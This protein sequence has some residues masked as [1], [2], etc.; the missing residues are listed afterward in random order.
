MKNKTAVLMITCKKFSQLW[1]PFFMLFKKFWP[2][3]PYDVFMG[4]DVGEHVGI[5][6]ISIGKD[7]GWNK[8]CLYFLNYL[9]HDRVI[10]FFDDFLPCAPFKTQKIEELVEHS[11]KYNIGCLRLFP[12]P[13]PTGVW[14]PNPQLGTLNPG[15]AYMFSWQTAIWDR[16]FLI[17]LVRP[18]EDPWKTETKGTKRVWKSNRHFVSV[19]R[20]ESPTPYIISI[21]KRKWQEGALELLR[22][23]NIPTNKITNI[24]K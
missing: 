23:E 11:F 2:D 4:T 1:E 6:T 12:C 21:V 9:H 17:S 24:I 15:D 3:C 7:L 13:G 20:G 18:N 8:N 5:K 14:K 19:K 16:K 10:I 22:R